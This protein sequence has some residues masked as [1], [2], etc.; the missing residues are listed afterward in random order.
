[1]EQFET[2]RIE[3]E[4]QWARAQRYGNLNPEHWRGIYRALRKENAQWVAMGRVPGE[5]LLNKV[6][7][8]L[9]ALSPSFSERQCSSSLETDSEPRRSDETPSWDDPD[10]PPVGKRMRKKRKEPITPPEIAFARPVPACP[11]QSPELLQ[12]RR[13]RGR[14]PKNRQLS[15]QLAPK[16]VRKP[17]RKPAQKTLKARNS[18]KGAPANSAKHHRPVTRSQAVQTRS[19]T[20]QSRSNKKG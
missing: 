18:A 15:T 13:S 17:A 11:E 4:A 19:K 8:D 16:A 5:T 9:R 12:P 3:S 1:M 6:P 14:P 2:Y 20:T 10:Y 7:I